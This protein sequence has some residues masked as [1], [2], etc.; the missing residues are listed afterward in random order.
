MKFWL[1]AII[2]LAA[3]ASPVAHADPV[4]D[5]YRGKQLS[6]LIRAAPG[7]N[8]DT[9]MRLLGRHLSRHIPGNPTA[10]PQNMPGAGG[11]VALNYMANV[12]PQDGT[13]LMMLSA[14]S[15]MDQALGLTPELKT[16]MR[17]LHW[18]GNISAENLFVV[19]GPKSQQKTLADAVKR[20]T[21]LA[22]SGAGGSEVILTAILNSG[23]G[24]QFKNI[25]GYRSG[26]EMSLA[27]DRGE[28]DGRWTTN[29]RALFAA[30]KNRSAEGI[31]EGYNVLI[32]IGIEKDKQFQ[33]PPL[34]RELPSDPKYKGAIELISPVIS[35]ARPIAAAQNVPADRVAALRKAFMATMAD[36][37]F[38]EEASRLDL[39]ISPMEGAALQTAIEQIV[40]APADVLSRIRE[41]AQ[42]T[43]GGNR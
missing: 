39:E 22:G 31:G 4:E 42:Q 14:S 43:P 19:T 13:V 38:L 32:Q 34:A 30:S 23:I 7:G 29:L 2:G 17:K 26:P 21:T 1:P 5:F 16:D 10:V 15:P 24:T 18:I 28:T 11:L 40:D 6:L 12:A 36:P 8:Y 41:V 35:I 37:Q 20:V 25:P 3:L 33:S 9:Y 27:M